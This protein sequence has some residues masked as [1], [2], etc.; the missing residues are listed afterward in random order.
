[1]KRALFFIFAVI[2]II[3][4]TSCTS[5]T[6][7]YQTEF[8]GTFDT[9][10]SVI[11]YAE[12]QN[13]FTKTAQLIH[14]E[15]DYLNKLF[16]I[17]NDY[18]SINNIKT[19]NDNAGSTVEVDPLII[20][21]IKDAK[22]W[23]QKTNGAVNIA[24]GPV[25]KIWH[26]YRTAGIEHPEKAQLPPM[27]LLEE[28]AKHCDINK[29]VIDEKNNTVTIEQE[30]RLDVGSVAKGFA[31]QKTAEK[32][33]DIG[34]DNIL[35]SA[36]GN[37]RAIGAPADDRTKWG[38]GLKDPDSTLAYST[39][40]ENLLDVAYVDGLSVVTSGSYERYYTVNEKNYH[41]IIDNKTLMPSEYY[42]SVTVITNDS[43]TADVLSTALFVMAPDDALEFVEDLDEVEALWVLADGEIIRS[44]GMA[45]YL[46]DIGG[47]SNR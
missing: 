7:Q 42:K 41:H 28:A 20:E 13:E 24:L 29:V 47:A 45:A 6:Q 12:S 46:R 44:S 31:A 17:Y 22:K 9:M 38:V 26:D 8:F 39:S 40:A 35:I 11:G 30:M 3:S 43:T 37:V 16:D 1:M 5:S 21:L 19:I 27:E 15:F 34:I 4:L 32:L 18:N 10:V 25:L 36:G 33:M 14:D 2:I 23:H